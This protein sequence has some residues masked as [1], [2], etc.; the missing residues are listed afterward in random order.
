MRGRYTP[1]R[2]KLHARYTSRGVYGHCRPNR[3][4][5]AVQITGAQHNSRSSG[6]ARAHTTTSIGALHN[7][8]D[9]HK[10][11][12]GCTNTATHEYLT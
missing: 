3:G 10:Y 4:A 2:R 9:L 8:A 12:A 11:S 1:K 5:E 7:Y 6:P